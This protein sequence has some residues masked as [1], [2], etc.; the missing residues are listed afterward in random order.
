MKMAITEN[1]HT[2]MANR[3]LS[4]FSKGAYLKELMEGITFYEFAN[5]LYKNFDD[6]Y[7]KICEN[8]K[9][10]LNALYRNERS[11]RTDHECNGQYSEVS[12]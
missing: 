11:E 8:L 7:E 12:E 6:S 2:A 1:G 10:A 5:A 4:Y 3:A 9:A